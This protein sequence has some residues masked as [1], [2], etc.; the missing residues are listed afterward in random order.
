MIDFLSSPLMYFFLTVAIYLL[1]AFLVKKTKSAL[2]NP[3][4]WTIIFIAGYLLL[5][6]YLRNNS[7]E[8]GY[9]ELETTKYR[10]SA[11][12]FNI[13]LAPV[14]VAL[15]IPLYEN[16]AILK[17]YWLAILVATIV[18]TGTSVATVFLLGHLLGMDLTLIYALTPRGVTT[19]IA[20]EIAAML[21]ASV[22]SPL[23][24]SVVALTG[25]VGATLGP[26]V[27]RLF[28]DRDDVIVGLSLGSASHAIG[29]SKAFDYSS[30]AGAIA[31]VSIIT[32]GLLTVIVAL[33]IDLI[34]KA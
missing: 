23:T 7:L 28:R 27:I 2:F 17:E 14:T 6:T 30:R 15:A 5:I 18:G 34:A 29:T 33:V 22:Y 26:L 19:A 16:R 13:L 10:D 21:G 31:S 3:L 8:Q 12:I 11:N 32:N 4:L 9:I 20:T 24:V 25:I 1:F